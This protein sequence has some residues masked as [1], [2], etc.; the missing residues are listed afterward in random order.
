MA[1][2]RFSHSATA[3]PDGR[4]LIT[5]GLIEPGLIASVD[6][7]ILAVTAN[8]YLGSAELYDPHTGK[9]TKIGPMLSRRVGHTATLLEDGRVLLAGGNVDATSAEVYVP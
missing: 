8:S 1:T 7:G 4:V 6:P 5:G 9:F 2:G 3:L